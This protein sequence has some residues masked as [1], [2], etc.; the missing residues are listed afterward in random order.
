MV[1]MRELQ[2]SAKPF[3]DQF[4]KLKTLMQGIKWAYKGLKDA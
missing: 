1:P 2:E 3:L 4:K